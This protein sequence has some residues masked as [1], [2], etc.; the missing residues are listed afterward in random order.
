MQE[1]EFNLLEESWIK[2]ITPSLEQKEVSLLD[3]ILHAHE[4]TSLSGETPT[5]DVAVLRVLL[6]LVETI[7]YRYNENGEAY[8]LLKD[9]DYDMVLERWEN[10]WALG[11]FPER[12]V[13]DYLKTWEERFWLF[14][15]ETPFWQVSNLKY[16]TDYNLDCLFGNIKESN[17]TDTKHH[18]SMVDGKELTRLCYE[19]AARWLIHL[20]AYGGNIKAK[21]GVPG[22]MLSVGVGR[23]GQLGVVMINGSHLFETLMLN[24]CP[25]REDKELWG[26]PK[27]T[28]EKEVC[29]LQSNQIAPPDN[30]PELYT[31]Q[32][33]RIMLKREEG[34]VT[35]FRAMG[36]DFYSVEY[37]FNANEPMTLWKGIKDKKLGKT[38]YDPKLHDPAVHAWREFPTLFKR[39]KEGHSPGVVQW[40]QMLCEEKMIAPRSLLTFRMVGMVYG[41][42][43]RYTYD[44]CVDDTIK[45]SAEILK[46][47]GKD[48][49]S[50]ITDEVEKCQSV[51]EALKRLAAKL[52]KLFY[53]TGSAKSNIKDL[54]V[55]RYYFSIDHAFRQWL[56]GIDPTQGSRE[57]KLVE[58]ERKSSYFARKVVDDYIATLGMDIFTYKG[59]DKN[60]LTVPGIQNEYRRELRKIY[61]L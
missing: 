2:V 11:K 4:Y 49:V 1:K 22:T 43:W 57:E 33:R 23:L 59:K 44:D 61:K 42:S 21:K 48:W 39:G 6:A 28:W 14:H 46:E 18:F 31:M 12:A 19:E 37:D 13:R 16:G 17:N 7:F 53:G 24:L 8:E 32:S 41:A 25:L 55:S 36:G 47:L 3:V 52:N 9:D 27:P 30:L 45:M 20:N 38:I 58:W 5:Q 50:L 54:L 29:V 35:G 56:A 60:L 40:M 34:Y 26:S 10:Y 15:P 51:A